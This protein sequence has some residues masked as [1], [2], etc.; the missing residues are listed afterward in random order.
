MVP[1]KAHRKVVRLE[2]NVELGGRDLPGGEVGGGHSNMKEQQAQRHGG[3]REQAHKIAW[4]STGCA[5]GHKRLAGG[6]EH[7]SLPGQKGPWHQG[8]GFLLD[9][10]Q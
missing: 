10:L 1:W 2:L 9:D 5:K 6:G 3:E 4:L 7:T 8:I